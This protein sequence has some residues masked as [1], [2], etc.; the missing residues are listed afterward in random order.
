[1]DL[2]EFDALAEPLRRKSAEAQARHGFALIDGHI[3]TPEVI[4]L[5]ESHMGVVLPDKY[6]IFMT[7]YGG[8]RFGFVE[9]LPVVAPD[10]AWR[11]LF[12]EPAV[13]P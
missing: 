7:R 8:G 10:K 1:V 13:V 5:V 4:A 6:R 3:A 2:A 11:C 12:G 9:L